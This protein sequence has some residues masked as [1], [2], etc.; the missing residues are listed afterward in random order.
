VQPPQDEGVSR[1]SCAA[2]F[3]SMYRQGN[4]SI[5]AS[6]YHTI[7]RVPQCVSLQSS[8][9]GSLFTFN[10]TTVDFPASVRAEVHELAVGPGLV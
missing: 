6:G 3:L 4:Q 9:L 7:K 5:D 2:T 1:C 10:T 8:S